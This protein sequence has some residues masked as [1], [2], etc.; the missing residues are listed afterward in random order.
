MLH[1]DI[2]VHLLLLL[3]D[4]IPLLAAE[5][6]VELLQC[7]V[8]YESACLKTIVNLQ[9]VA[10][11]GQDLVLLDLYL[12]LGLHFLAESIKSW[13]FISEVE[14]YLFV[15]V[16][17]LVFTVICLEILVLAELVSHVFTT[18]LV[19]YGDSEADH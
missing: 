19:L 10:D 13:N 8:Q 3:V 2:Q 5:W 14:I 15:D 17:C 1:H 18:F 12:R 16:I 11:A 9:L 4:V 7:L 6:D